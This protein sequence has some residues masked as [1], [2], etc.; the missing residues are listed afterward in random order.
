MLVCQ[1]YKVFLKKIE[2]LNQGCKKYAHAIEVIVLIITILG[3][4]TTFWVYYKELEHQKSDQINEV[5]ANAE[6][7]KVELQK[8]IETAN[9]LEENREM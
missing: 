3:V 2:S 1:W 4:G 6:S 9:I 5:I 8:N 7:L